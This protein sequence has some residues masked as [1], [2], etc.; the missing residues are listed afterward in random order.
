MISCEML[1]EISIALCDAKGNTEPFGGIKI[2]FAGDFA[3]LPPIAETK[4]FARWCSIF[5]SSNVRGQK[6][7]SGRLLWLGVDTVVI[8][9]QPCRQCD[10]PFLQLLRRLREGACTDEDFVLLDSRRL[11]RLD[12][13]VIAAE[14]WANVP[15][16]VTD[17]ATKDMLNEYAVHQ[18]ARATNQELHWYFAEDKHK[19]KLVEDDDLIQHLR[20]LDSGKTSHALGKIPL[21]L[22][23]PVFIQHNYDVEHGIA[24]GTRGI[25]RHIRYTL[26]A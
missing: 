12:P 20:S 5:E 7:V 25:L 18:F 26:N 10:G 4:L 16:I 1:A 6:K 15:V 17:N 3:Q 19:G 9:E 8:L 14:D 22:G 21:V 13:S 11:D 24:N 23:M 2:V